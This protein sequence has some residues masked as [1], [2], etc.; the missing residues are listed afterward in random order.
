MYEWISVKNRL[1]TEGQIVDVYIPAHE[2]RR[3]SCYYVK[4]KEYWL[5]RCSKLEY[6]VTHWMPLPE[7]PY[8]C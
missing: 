6:C 8:E 5:W 3:T 1:P 2:S 7:P 4:D